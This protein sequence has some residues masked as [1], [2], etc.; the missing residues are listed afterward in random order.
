LTVV[1]GD[2]PGTAAARRWWNGARRS[3]AT[4]SRSHLRLAWLVEADRRR[5]AG[6][7]QRWLGAAV[8]GSSGGRGWWLGRWVAA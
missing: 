3:R 8:L 7:R 1:G 6:C 4:D 5:R 2:L